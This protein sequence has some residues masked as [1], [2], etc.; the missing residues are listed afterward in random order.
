MNYSSPRINN[1]I[2]N[3]TIRFNDGINYA[4]VF[5]NGTKHLRKVVDSTLS[6]SISPGKGIYLIP[7]SL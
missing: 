1:E 3:A 5:E 6:F 4:L 2:K 7:L